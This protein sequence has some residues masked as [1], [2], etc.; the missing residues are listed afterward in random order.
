MRL[1][2]RA[3]ADLTEGDEGA[4]VEKGKTSP[5]S[6]LKMVRAKLKLVTTG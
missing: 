2:L 4:V 5:N 6:Y 3:G 1:L